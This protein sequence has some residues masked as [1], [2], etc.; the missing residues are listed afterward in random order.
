ML[1]ARI[2]DTPWSEPVDAERGDDHNSVSPEMTLALTRELLARSRATLDGMNRRLEGR[3]ERS[4][5]PQGADSEAT[6]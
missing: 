5:T 1:M 3:E 6:G 4:D 2:P